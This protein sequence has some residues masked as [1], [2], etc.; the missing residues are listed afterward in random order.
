MEIVKG[1]RVGQERKR[2]GKG[3]GFQKVEKNMKGEDQRVRKG[4]LSE[5]KRKYGCRNRKI[6]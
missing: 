1:G 6:R 3:D 2:W 5:L 4:D